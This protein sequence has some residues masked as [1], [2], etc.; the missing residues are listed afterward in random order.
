MAEPYPAARQDVD[1]IP[2][3]SGIGLRFQHHAAFLEARPKVAWVEVHTENY[4][5]GPA[6]AVLER[7]R[8]DYKVSLHGV[9]LSLGSAEGLDG[10]HLDRV[11]EL[12]A[13]IA[14]GLMSEHLAWMVVDHAFLSDLLPLP[15]TGESLAVVCRNVTRAQDRL[16]RPILV[17]NPSTYLQFEHSTIPEGEFLA[18]MAARTGCGL[19]CDVN[20]IAVS[21]ANHGWDPLAYL[22]ALPAAAIGEFHLAGHSVQEVAPGQMLRLDTHDRPVDPAVWSL[23]EAALAVI[24]PR[25]TLI[26]WDADVPP[27]DTLLD[28]AARAE[29]RLRAAREG[30]V[31][32]AA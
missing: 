10:A 16:K 25:P 5:S 6:L 32:L 9:G 18:E 14:P 22:R 15:L 7:V 3:A 26:E 4:L 24:G 11:A 2:P 23:F 31:D 8:R 29:R 13:R 19:I 17:E 1:P 20:N 28:E 21:T 30:S 27:L 12:A